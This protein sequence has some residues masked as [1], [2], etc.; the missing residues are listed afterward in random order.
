MLFAW[1]SDKWLTL[2]QQELSPGAITLQR[3]G[4]HAFPSPLHIFQAVEL[5]DLVS[6][7]ELVDRLASGLSIR[8]SEEFD[9]SKCS[10]H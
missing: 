6:C 10:Q 5:T 9:P 4:S 1:L 7:R 2:A 8:I 3:V